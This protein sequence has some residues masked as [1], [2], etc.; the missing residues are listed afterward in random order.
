MTKV[1]QELFERLDIFLH[2]PLE[3]IISE[4][5]IEERSNVRFKSLKVRG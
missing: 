2:S 1:L 5:V 3:N 4:F